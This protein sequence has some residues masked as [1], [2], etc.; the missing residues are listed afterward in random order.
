MSEQPIASARGLLAVWTD[1]DPAGEADFNAWYSGQHLIERVGVPGFRSG[2]RYAAVEG[3]SPD[4]PRYFAAYDT[5]D[6]AVL[7]SPAYKAR[8]DDPT[9]WTQ[10]V[11]PH[12]RNTVRFVGTVLASHGRGAAGI[13]RTLRIEPAA[14]RREALREGLRTLVER[15]LAGAEGVLRVRLMVRADAPA[16]QPATQTA[17]TK[18]RGPD[19]TATF[20]ILLEAEFT[21]PLDNA[22]AS[23][24]SAER[25]TGL[26][27]EGPVQVADYQLLYALAPCL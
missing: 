3:T 26:G 27:A 2:C 1:A 24:L 19:A 12:F 17:E 5:D 23:A 16:T 9:P 11:M 22:C 8:L 6:A 13:V 20:V 21:A 10:R 18:L 14:G 4:V 7:S 25:L 15:E